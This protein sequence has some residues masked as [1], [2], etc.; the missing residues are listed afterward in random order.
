[1]RT[2]DFSL[3]YT[4]V[5]SKCFISDKEILHSRKNSFYVVNNFKVFYNCLFD[6]LQFFQLAFASWGPLSTPDGLQQDLPDPVELCRPR[7]ASKR[8]CLILLYSASFFFPFSNCCRRCSLLGLWLILE[9]GQTIKN[10]NESIHCVIMVHS[11]LR[12]S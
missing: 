7:T 1:L 4:I 9:R 6:T 2:L 8:T 3:R 5:I 12:S 11:I 10:I